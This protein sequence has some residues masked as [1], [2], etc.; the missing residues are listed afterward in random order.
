MVKGRSRLTQASCRLDP[1]CMVNVDPMKT[2]L[3]R[4]EKRQLLEDGYVIV[5]NAVTDEAVTEAR[6][7]I[8]SFL[9]SNEHILLVPPELATNDKITGL[10]AD[11]ALSVIL[12]NVMG[13]FPPVVSCQV[14]VIPPFNRLGGIPGTHVDGGWSGRLP[15]TAQEIDLVTGRP[16]DAL[17]YFGEHDE[18]RGTNDGLLWQDPQRTLSY[19]SY[20]ALVG[21][22]L[23]D[24]TVPGNGQFGVLRG[25]HEQVQDC[26][27]K[28]RAA[29]GPIGPEG[30][31]W[32][33]VKIDS[34]GRPYSNGLPDD[35]REQAAELAK[36]SVA[37]DDWPWPE[38]TPILL[39][40]GDAIIALHSL[41]H[42]PTP[43]SGPDPRM[44]IYFRIRRYR[45]GN[46]HEGSRRLAHGVSDH[47]DRGYFGQFLDYPSSYNPWQTSIDKLCDHW[48]EWDGMQDIVR[49]QISIKQ[50]SE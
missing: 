44:N 17:K 22:A 20:T 47:P 45:D 16:K 24:Q 39:N 33:R 27:R 46:P 4:P 13:P 32:P 35:I 38:L 31:G 50:T 12:Q 26:F 28:Q 48:S 6:Q 3:S 37:T 40:A 23:N 2:D 34:Q 36:Q 43:N 14:A 10:F 8:Q 5:R 18:I 11:S 21:I 30:P 41:P 49:E 1:T 25:M 15:K 7:L 19:G 42:T 29:G 9:P